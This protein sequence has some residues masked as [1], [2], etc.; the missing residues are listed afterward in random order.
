[1][2]TKYLPWIS[3]LL[4]SVGVAC[5]DDDS[6][7]GNGDGTSG[8]GTSD[9]GTSGPGTSGPGT[10]DSGTD[11]TPD[12]GDTGGT[13]TPSGTGTATDTGATTGT[14]TVTDTGT[15]TDTGATTGT[16]TVTGT[17][18]P[19]ATATTSGGLS[20]I[21]D[22]V[23]TACTNATWINDTGDTLPCPG[24]DSDDEGFVIFR[25]AGTTQG[26]TAL[27]PGNNMETHPE[28]DTYNSCLQGG[29]QDCFIYGRYANVAVD[30]GYRFKATVGC[31]QGGAA[32]D[33]NFIVR[34][35]SQNAGQQLSLANENVAYSD[36]DTVIDVSMDAMAG[37]SDWDL[38]LM[39]TPGAAT[40][41]DWAMWIE[42]RIEG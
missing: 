16:G 12:T 4:L 39:V 29:Q 18:T 14:G 38:D 6:D 37:Y 9:T 13:E 32:C 33:V 30:A 11:S 8:S 42:P 27:T 3:C 5:S 31:L 15:A 28:W 22:L 20:V 34:A 21:L 24:T 26:G 23:A 25:D 10:G 36:G 1:M 17:G 7:S 41:Q 19:T 2:Q 35:Q 40:T